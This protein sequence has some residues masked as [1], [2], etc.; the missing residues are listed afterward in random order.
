MNAARLLAGRQA[1]AEAIPLWTSLWEASPGAGAASHPA[2]LLGLAD[3][4]RL[5]GDPILFHATSSAGGSPILWPMRRVA[6]GPRG[7]GLRTLTSMAGWHL[8]PSDLLAAEPCDPAAL[9]TIAQCLTSASDW[10]LLQLNFLPQ[11]TRVA[12]LLP[13]ATCAEAGEQR[14]VPLAGTASL[15]SGTG[16][17]RMRQYERR[18]SR[19]GDAEVIT[20]APASQVAEIAE[21]FMHLHTMRWAEEG[22][23]AEFREPAVRSRI[24]AWME[25]LHHRGLLVLGSIRLD[26]KVVAAHVALCGHT[27]RVAWRIAH[28]P[29]F[30]ELSL[31]RLLF[32]RMIEQARADGVAWYGMGRGTEPYKQSWHAEVTPLLRCRMMARRPATVLRRAVTRG[33]GLIA[34]RFA[35]ASPERGE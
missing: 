3:A 22:A 31:G 2:V 5:P 28:A 25:D 23:A 1:V 33:M 8:P 21:A 20:A 30:D 24:V 26:G 17:A 16:A 35:G 14:A 18:L 34:R 29:G 27:D 11:T 9:Q 4:L 15:Y 6:G 13:T 12:A 7:L 10:D 19:R 32:A